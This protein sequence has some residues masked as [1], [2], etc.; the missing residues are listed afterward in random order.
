MRFKYILAI[1]LLGC[2]TSYVHTI[3]SPSSEYGS[4]SAYDGF[5]GGVTDDSPPDMISIE[6]EN[7]TLAFI[8]VAA[9]KISTKRKWMG[10]FPIPFR[11][12][13][14]HKTFNHYSDSSSLILAFSVFHTDSIEIDP[15]KISILYK[16]SNIK[17]THFRLLKYDHYR[18]G[19]DYK[20]TFKDLSPF[21]VD[22]VDTNLQLMPNYIYNMFTTYGFELKYPVNG[23]LVDS[24]FVNIEGLNY[25]NEYLTFPSIYFEKTKQKEIQIFPY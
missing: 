22:T 9:Q 3:H 11:F 10:V 14:L 23:T 4:A 20:S 13:P 18:S 5:H 7:D 16:D 2:S 6:F 21:F 12:I 17:P 24:F 8:L 1:L 19:S 15:S 25:E